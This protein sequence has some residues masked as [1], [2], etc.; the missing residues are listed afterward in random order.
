MFKMLT[1]VSPLLIGVASKYGLSTHYH[2]HRW[3]LVVASGMK[4]GSG[5]AIA[6]STIYQAKKHVTP[7]VIEYLSSLQPVHQGFVLI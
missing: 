4:V 6:G 2:R 5:P 7:A 3:T 1:Q